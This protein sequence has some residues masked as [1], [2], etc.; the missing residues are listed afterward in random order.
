MTA[1]TAE[2]ILPRPAAAKEPLDLLHEVSR[3]LVSILDGEELLRRVAELVKPL[4]DYQLFGVFLW[5]PVTEEL[6]SVVSVRQDGC[7]S[8]KLRFILDCVFNHTGD[9]GII[10]YDRS[11]WVA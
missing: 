9:Q 3:E 11:G 2:A 4:V 10:F 1:A 8:R 7:R 5:N 6:E